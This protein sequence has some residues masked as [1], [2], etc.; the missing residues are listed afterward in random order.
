TIMHL[1]RAEQ[2]AAHDAE[3][4]RTLKADEKKG[5]P[6]LAEAHPKALRARTYQW[7]DRDTFQREGN[8]HEINVAQNA[9][10]HRR[11]QEQTRVAQNELEQQ[12][13][14]FVTPNAP[15]TRE[16]N[17]IAADQAAIRAQR[18]GVTAPARHRPIP[19]NPIGGSGQFAGLTHR[20]RPVEQP[21]A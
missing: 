3:R 9:R 15:P 14:A 20:G 21:R 10:R 13:A 7:S 16:P 1:Y 11:A 8:R 18:E 19:Q 4:V 6:E 17:L 5:V 12:Q 2:I